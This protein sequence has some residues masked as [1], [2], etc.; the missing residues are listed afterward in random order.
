MTDINLPQHV[1]II[2]DGNGRWAKKRKLPRAAGHR[3]GAKAVER[4]IAYSVKRG[5]Q[6]LTLFALSIENRLN[7]PDREIHLLLSLFLDALRRHTAKLHEENVQ[8]KIVG[9]RS[10]LEATLRQQIAETEKLTQSNTG[11]QLRIAINYSGR[12]DILQAMRRAMQAQ[13]SPEDIDDVTF[14]QFLCFHDVPEPDLLIR[15]SGEKRISNF[16]LWQCA[17]TE[18]FFTD[19]FW[20]DFDDSV[21][22]QAIDSF[23]QRE[24]RFGYTSEQLEV[25]HA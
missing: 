16:F 10:F 19:A 22:A 4:A 18:L 2:M 24:R 14:Q 23:Q 1:A 6:A 5:I 20:P 3:A 7:R 15:T 25:A 11:L 13:L 12:W 21:Y 8:V 9:D 17:Y